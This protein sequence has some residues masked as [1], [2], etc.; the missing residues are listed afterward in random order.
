MRA[1]GIGFACDTRAALLER[2]G[3]FL[4]AALRVEFGSPSPGDIRRQNGGRE[5]CETEEEDC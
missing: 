3:V 5:D 2:E 1:F 4:Q